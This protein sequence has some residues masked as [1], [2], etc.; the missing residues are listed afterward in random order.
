[1]S[2]IFHRELQL[3]AEFGELV[4]VHRDFAGVA[5]LRDAE[6]LG[7]ER[8]EVEVEAGRAVLLR[9]LAHD[10]DVG[11]LVLALE[12][13]GVVGVDQ[14]HDLGEVRDAEAEGERAVGAVLLE[15]VH[16]QLQVD[17][18][19]VA[20]VH[21]LQRNALGRGVDVHVRHQIF[22]GVHDTLEYLALR[23]F[24]R[25]KIKFL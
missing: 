3:L 25:E 9:V 1:M 22:D 5:R 7:V 19:D 23:V 8:D 18:G 20:G 2:I 11:W 10:G 16:L 17:E 14:L 15:P 24:D 12:R 6:V 13:D 21:G 4:R